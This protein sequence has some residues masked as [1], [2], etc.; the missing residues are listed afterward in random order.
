MLQKRLQR[1]ENLAAAKPALTDVC[2]FYTRLYQL[3]ADALPFLAVDADLKDAKSRQEQGFPLLRG[4]M[5][6]IDATAAQLFFADLLQVLRDHG[7]QGQ[8]EL[9]VLQTALAAGGL[10]LP[11]LLR[12]VFER[13]REPLARTAEKLQVQPALLEYSLTTAL[14]AALER[15]RQQGLESAVQGW[16]HGYCP[17]CGGL[18]AIAELSGEEGKKRLQCGLCGNHWAFKRLTCI[19]CGNTDH[20]TLAYFTAEGES[21]CRVDVCRKCSGYLKV[22]DSRERSDDFPL[23]IEDV[24]TLHLDLMAAREGFSRGKKETPGN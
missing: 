19:H 9:A 14:G 12:A 5:L 8:E 20:E 10:D 4:E 3:F 11:K 7:Q 22:V 21:G 1:L 24:A 15:C 18:P 16:D 17:I 23:E 13:D 2:R 6:R